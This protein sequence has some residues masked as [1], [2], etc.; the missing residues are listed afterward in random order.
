LRVNISFSRAREKEGTRRE[1]VGR[2]RV[3]SFG[4]RASQKKTLT[5]TLSR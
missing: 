4:R 1:A 3:F 2:M 5:P